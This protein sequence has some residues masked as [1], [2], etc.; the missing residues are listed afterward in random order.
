MAAV[1]LCVSDGELEV[2]ETCALLTATIPDK[3]DNPVKRAMRATRRAAAKKDFE[4]SGFTGASQSVVVAS[5]K[6]RLR[7][8]ILQQ[9]GIADAT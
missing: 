1:P 9:R 5:A 7:I 8:S 6:V 4:R 3:P 2:P